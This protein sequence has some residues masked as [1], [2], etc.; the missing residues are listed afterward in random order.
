MKK[1]TVLLCAILAL[2][3]AAHAAEEIAPQV[4]AWLGEDAVLLGETREG[5]ARVL[6]YR[7]QATE[8]TLSLEDDRPVRLEASAQGAVAASTR[9]E[10]EAALAAIAPEALVLYAAQQ[11]DGSQRLSFVAAAAVGWAQ[12]ADGRIA[13]CE[14]RFG[15]YLRDGRLTLNGA[16]EALVIHRPAAQISGL[17]MDEEDGMLIFEGDAVLEGTEYEFEIDAYS[18]RLLEWERD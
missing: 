15:D 8:M 7:A 9:E 4:L 16:W 14:L 1:L 10:A 11:E 3:G 13:A 5:N 17:E 12:I 2:A 18:G 6:S